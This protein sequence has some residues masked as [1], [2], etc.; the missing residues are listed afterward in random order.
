MNRIVSLLFCATVLFCTAILSGCGGDAGP[1]PEAG[2]STGP[3]YAGTDVCVD[4]HEE[5]AALWRGSDHELAMQPANDRSVLGDFDGAQ[6]LHNGVTSRFF[7]RGGNYFVETDGPD[8]HLAEFPVR[9]TFGVRPLQQYLLELPDGKIQT[10]GVSWDSRPESEGGQR[11]FHVYGDELIDHNDVLHWTRPS[12]NWDSMC[13]FCHSTGLV[14]TFDAQKKTFSTSWAEINVACEA[15]HGPGSQHV[16]WASSGGKG[17]PENPDTRKGFAVRFDERDGVSW[18]LDRRSGN[19][20]RSR[21]RT[22]TVEIDTCAACHSRRSQISRHPRPGDGLL[23]DF[24]PS[25]ISAPLY[26]VDGQVRDEDYVYGSFLQSRM[27]QHGVTC[28]DCHEPHSLSLRAPGSKM[29]L[30]CHAAEKFDT[31]E[32]RLHRAGSA[33]ASCIECHMPPTTYMQ[34]DSRHDHSFRLPRP[35]LSLKFG[36][37]NA[38]TNCH[39]DRDPEWAAGI[40]RANDKLPDGKHWQ[41]KLATILSRQPGTRG[42]ID[43]LSVDTSVPAIIRASAIMQAPFYRD[44]AL[45]ERLAALADSEEPLIRWAVARELQGAPAPLIARYAS[46]M[47]DDPLRAVRIAAANALAPVALELLPAHA[48]SKLRPVLNE[49]I[50]AEL[51]NN[52]RAEAHVNIGN[53]QRNLRHPEQAEQAYRIALDLNPFF[54]PATVNLADLYKEQGRETDGETLLRKAIDLLPEQPALHYALGLSL[55]RQGRTGEAQTELRRAAASTGAEPRMALAYALILDA[56][57]ETGEAIAYLNGALEYFGDDPGLL[58]ALIN[59]YQRTNRQKDAAALITRLR[60][61]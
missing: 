54:V 5:Q 39:E 32:H 60:N 4:C 21:P 26:H 16:A 36:T 44:A 57:G 33:G 7:R 2:A 40:L 34:V 51:V 38:C 19:S 35:D 23:D 22:T 53:L 37:P 20:T 58:A 45:I 9:Y 43:E 29:C 56:Q 42:L 12:Q 61:L 47:L 14:K 46:A 27:Y 50:E 3:T 55:V 48:Q 49:S 30:K 6:F 10:L 15:C 11:W 31:T 28:S 1:E 25:L 18:M 59:L 17:D 13:A 8:G 52:E 41:K 24:R